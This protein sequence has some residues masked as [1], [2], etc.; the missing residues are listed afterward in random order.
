MEKK[1]KE[2]PAQ[3][4]GFVSGASFVGFTIG[5]LLIVFLSLSLIIKGKEAIDVLDKNY[6]PSNII[7][8][9]GEGKISVMPDVVYLGYDVETKDKDAKAVA[10]KSKETIKNFISFLADQGISQDNVWVLNYSMRKNTESDAEGKE[11]TAYQITETIKAKIKDKEKLAEKMKTISDK[12][13]QEGMTPNLGYSGCGGDSE[14]SR[15]GLYID[16]P[17]QYNAELISKALKDAKKQ[18]I[19][20]TRMAGLRLGGIVGVADY[21]SYPPS[22]C[23]VF[24][25]VGFLNK[26]E[27]KKDISVTFEVKR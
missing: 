21:S 9:T 24:A 2:K 14:E 15:T 7:S 4:V 25:D 8:V 17:E 10:E 20:Q 27:V 1:S 18:A 23:G 16:D 11:I 12:A 26:I 13:M 3:T 6:Y 22:S 5:A 19:E